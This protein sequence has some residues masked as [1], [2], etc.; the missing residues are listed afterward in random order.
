MPVRQRVILLHGSLSVGPG[1]KDF[2]IWMLK[3]YTFAVRPYTVAEAS[4]AEASVVGSAE[5][6]AVVALVVVVSVAD[7]RKIRLK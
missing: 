6:S 5:D 1:P 7:D 2:G 3:L 4:V